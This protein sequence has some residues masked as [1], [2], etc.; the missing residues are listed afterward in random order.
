MTKDEEIADLRRQLAAAQADA[1][2]RLNFIVGCQQ[3][4]GT[5]GNL[6]GEIESLI[7]RA[8]KAEA[9]LARAQEKISAHE[10]WLKADSQ[11]AENER[12]NADLAAEKERAD[13]NWTALERVKGKW[14]DTR[15][16]LAAARTALAGE[17]ACHA[18][19]V[20]SL[21]ANARKDAERLRYLLWC[22]W[23]DGSGYGDDGEMQFDGMDFKRDPI[24]L[25]EQKIQERNVS[26]IA[27]FSA[28]REEEPKC[29]SS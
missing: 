26:L 22:A 29:Q 23:D 16:E 18:S 27:A 17:F 5:H 3:L 11:Y 8:E 10:A 24:E 28:A 7:Q 15:A 25:L 2:R 12:L 21:I 4:L 1:E 20:N 9:E 6:Q 13:G 19:E 14:A